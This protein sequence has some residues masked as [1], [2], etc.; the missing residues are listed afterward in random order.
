MDFGIGFLSNNLMLPILDFFYGIVPSYGL[1]IV[2]L[3]LV[4]RF[5][6]Y[7]LNAGSIRNMRRMKVTQ[8]LMKERVDQIQQQHKDDP[9]KQ[10]EEMSRVYKEL[11]N[12][13]AGCFPLL[14][15]MPILFA[16]FATLRGSP[17]SDVNYSIDLQILPQAQIEQVQPQAYATKAQN[18]YFA[19]GIHTSVVAMIPG[20]NR[21]GLNEKVKVELQTVD[22]KPLK[23]ELEKYPEVN[24]IPTWKILK[25]EDK[26]QVGENGQ[27]LALAPGDATIQVGLRGLAS[28]KGFLF[29][30]ALGRVGAVDPDG[31]IH[32]DIVGMILAFGV[33]LYLNQVLSGQGSSSGNP[34]QDTV[35]KITP[36]L[37]SGMFFFFPLPA[38]VLLYMLIANIFQTVQAFI[39]SREPLPE[40][41]Q[42]IVEESS[43][44]AKLATVDGEREALPFEPGRSKKKAQS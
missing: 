8:P 18:Y 31:T 41:L 44:T 2:A 26:I 7:P 11:G 28:D 4:V 9:V 40:H 16:L 19:D 33:S 32:W 36:V 1:A 37:F 15:Q 12:P 38:G 20:G 13:L 29:I 43:K 6:L 5:A 39:L 27:I 35:N 42:K 10:R 23:S 30:D 3:T 17:F 34:Q 22:G 25:G 24:L 21:L 14:I